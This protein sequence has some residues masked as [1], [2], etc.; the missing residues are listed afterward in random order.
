MPA[1]PTTIDAYLAPLP[2]DQRAALQKL[3][4]TIH[5]AAPKAE[6]CLS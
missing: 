2:A 1:K 4:Q 3:R 6:E 5:S